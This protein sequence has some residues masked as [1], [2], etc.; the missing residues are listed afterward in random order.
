MTLIN[1]LSTGV[2]YLNS[3]PGQPFIPLWSLVYGC[4]SSAQLLLS[5]L[6]WC[7]CRKKDDESD[8]S[9]RLRKIS[10]FTE[11][12][13]ILFLVAWLIAGS[14]WVFTY[15]SQLDSVVG[16]CGIG[17]SDC[18]HTVVYWFSF[19][20]IVAIYAFI[21]CTCTCCCYFFCSAIFC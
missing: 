16:E 12:V 11:V 7:I 3:C 8:N 5:V 20:S 6:K 2:L 4:V 15:F 9:E 21:F 19:G 17:S 1:D 14:V 10:T 13:S 18:C